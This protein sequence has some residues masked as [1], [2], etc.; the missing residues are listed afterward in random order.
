M[1]DH[2]KFVFLACLTTL[3]VACQTSS[4]G[5]KEAGGTPSRSWEGA[6]NGNGLRGA[7]QIAVGMSS[8][9]AVVQS[10]AVYCWGAGHQGQL[11]RGNREAS[12]LPTRVAGINDAIAIDAGMNHTCALHRTGRISC[13]GGNH[14]AEL[15]DGSKEEALKPVEV[16]D[17]SDAVQISLGMSTSCALRN[18]GSVACWGRNLEQRANVSGSDNEHI[19]KSIKGL[20]KVKKLAV[21]NL[22]ICAIRGDEDKLVCVG[23]DHA[24]NPPSGYHAQLSVETSGYK[25]VS[26]VVAGGGFTCFERNDEW[27]CWGSSY[28]GQLGLSSSDAVHA[29]K[30]GS[31]PGLKNTA[32][33]VAGDAGA[34]AIDSAGA[35]Y[36]WG[37]DDHTVSSVAGLEQVKDVALS[38]SSHE[39]HACALTKE[40]L[41]V[42]W[43]SNK[44]GQLG[45]G[46]NASREMPV[47]VVEAESTKPVPNEKEK[48]PQGTAFVAEK[49]AAGYDETC[50]IKSGKVFCW[51]QRHERIYSDP[52]LYRRHPERVAGISNAVEIVA[53][54]GFMCARSSCGTVSCWGENDVMQLGDGTDKKRLKPVTVKGLK[55]A[56]QVVA[57]YGRACALLRNGTISCW[58]DRHPIEELKAASSWTG[59]IESISMGAGHMCLLLN[60]R[61]V[62]CQGS[63]AH[64]Q[65]GNGAG[66]CKP[67]PNDFMCGGPRS[68]CKPKMICEK[69]DEFVEVKDL[70][71]VKA[72]AL[73]GGFSCALGQSGRMWCWGKSSFGQLGI[74]PAD[75]GMEK[76]PRELEDL[77]GVV[78]MAPSSNHSCARVSSGKVYCWGQNVFAEIGDRTTQCRIRPAAVFKM[79]DALEVSAGMNHGCALRKGGEVWC[80]GK[81][82]NGVL[83][84]GDERRLHLIPG[85]VLED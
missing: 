7:I 10:G 64:G 51:G 60:N 67:D 68:R 72:I 52:G 70:P 78:Q 69:S 46:T 14:S 81:N 21:G 54:F 26:D 9:C 44:H 59:K 12:H 2:Y 36:C 4:P 28:R 55:N 58:G 6:A 19:P 82:D 5:K 18:N 42:C 80:W 29:E 1:N 66:G 39:R 8:S 63:N 17:I 84:V 35:V 77:D 62:V 23:L 74:G 56:V 27:S 85:P 83:G 13:W 24:I 38:L 41:V 47:L 40:G 71:D 48:T 76:L 25:G 3:F 57:D 30:A 11:G 43:G 45:D 73:G 49:L 32:K 61:K 50:A 65:I 16:L 53:G 22:H 15:G 34:C 79:D 33:I 37:N 75:S 31:V 20:E